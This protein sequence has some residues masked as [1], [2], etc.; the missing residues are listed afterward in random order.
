[1]KVFGEVLSVVCITIAFIAI[2]YL[3]GNTIIENTPPKC[4][5]G[6]AVFK[7]GNQTIRFC[8]ESKTN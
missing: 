7:D 2:A 8:E 6:T 4:F 3:Y 5:T 1:M